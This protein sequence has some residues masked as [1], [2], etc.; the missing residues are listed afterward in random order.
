MM[1][2]SQMV[3]LVRAKALDV[4]ACGIER[5]M[6]VMEGRGVRGAGG[7]SGA[8]DGGAG[9]V[10]CGVRREGKMANVG[11]GSYAPSVSLLAVYR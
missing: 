7:T 5:A 1:K 6:R 10:W 2:L 3:R 9:V 11:D 8:R 4:R